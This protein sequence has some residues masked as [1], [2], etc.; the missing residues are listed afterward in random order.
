M[1]AD[2][3]S[4]GIQNIY[5]YSFNMQ[6]W[7]AAIEALAQ[8]TESF[9]TRTTTQLNMI[10]M[11]SS[12]SHAE[13]CSGTPAKKQRSDIPVEFFFSRCWIDHELSLTGFL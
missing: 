11:S 10:S 6:N 9:D 3:V 5:N 1:S 7:N 12:S 8:L 4:G 2:F 13:T